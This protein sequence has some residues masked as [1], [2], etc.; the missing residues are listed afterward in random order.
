MTL[1]PEKILQYMNVQNDG[2]VVDKSSRPV[3]GTIE[4]NEF[5]YVPMLTE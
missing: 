2:G 5:I 4:T 3:Y 1:A